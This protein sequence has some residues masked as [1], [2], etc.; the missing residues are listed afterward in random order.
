[1]STIKEIFLF[2]AL[3]LLIAGFVGYRWVLSEQDREKELLDRQKQQLDTKITKLDKLLDG[4]INVRS[5][6]SEAAEEKLQ[7]ELSGIQEEKVTTK[8][9]IF[10]ISIFCLVVGTVIFT[11]WLL[12]SIVYCVRE[13]VKYLK[14]SF[15]FI[16]K[17]LKESGITQLLAACIEKVKK[18][19]EKRSL[20][21]L[22]KSKAKLLTKNKPQ[23][24]CLERENKRIDTLYYDKK[25]Y[26]PEEQANLVAGSADLNAKLIDQLEQNIRKTIL[27]G[28]HQHTRSVQNSLKAQNETLEKQVAEVMQIA[29]TITEA[30]AKNSEP[31][32]SSLDELTRQ[33]STIREYASLQHNRIEKL[34]E[35]YDWNIIRNFCLR[36]IRCIDNLET[37]IAKLSEQGVDTTELEEIMDELVFALE[38]SGVEQF[39]PEVNSDYNGQEK[40]AEVIKDKASANN[41]KME[42]KIAEV[43][44]PGYQ[45]VIDDGNVKVVRAARVKLFS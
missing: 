10:I 29:R 16:L 17:C 43:V 42:G 39:R 8:A 26:C 24:V 15:V 14:K 19:L 40:L 20:S 27:S 1:M 30:S 41:P 5:L 6:S 35:G 34:Q 22:Y 11:A 33:I 45:Y 9:D 44:K 25:S 12:F 13:G 31:V 21:K 18:I 4:E 23:S 36:I 37:R 2:L 3:V 28:Y 38:S 32:R 7:E